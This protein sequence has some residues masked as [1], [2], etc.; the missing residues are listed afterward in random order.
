[1]KQESL[2]TFAG[3]DEIAV[4]ALAGSLSNA[5]AYHLAARGYSIRKIRSTLVGQ[6]NI[7]GSTH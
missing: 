5:M 1:M 4:Q 7:S 2:L 6:P 3:T